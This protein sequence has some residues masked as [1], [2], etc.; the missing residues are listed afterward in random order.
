ME[1]R[2]LNKKVVTYGVQLTLLFLCL[3]KS[4]EIAPVADGDYLSSQQVSKSD[5]QQIDGTTRMQFDVASVKRN[6]SG[7]PPAGEAPTSN[8]PLGNGNVFPP[9]GGLFNAVNYPLA[10]YIIFAYKIDANQIQTLVSQV[11]KWV[12]AERFD[13]QARTSVAATK[14]D[15]RLMMQSLL[16]DRF[17]LAV[18]TETR[19]VPIFGLVL[20]VPSKLGPNLHRHSDHLP[21]ADPSAAPNP[22]GP[23][24]VGGGLPLTCGSVLMVPPSTPG[25]LRAA[26]RGVT[27]STIAKTLAAFGALDRPVLDN[28]GLDGS[29][30]FSLEW[31]RPQA[32]GTPA[33]GAG[34]ESDSSGTTF[35]QALREQLGLKLE[36]KKGSVDVILVDHIQEP[37]PN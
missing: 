37:S 17:K 34:S 10:N 4:A 19:D 9:N 26:G 11:P 35:L 2:M 27:I 1:S 12:V 36:A 30:D 14:D 13:I 3:T 6:T 18:H 25:H 31:S 7:P 23:W 22:A 5:K 16:A 20:A 8:I 15:M 33:S 24:T 29:F 21:C 28:T 32:N